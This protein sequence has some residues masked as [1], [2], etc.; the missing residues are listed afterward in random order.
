MRTESM[1]VKTSTLHII[2]RL[3]RK[4]DDD[5]EATCANIARFVFVVYKYR[6]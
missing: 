3:Q 4:Y 2:D 5:E 1:A 6:Q